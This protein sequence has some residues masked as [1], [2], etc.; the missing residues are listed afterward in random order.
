LF[1]HLI[2]IVFQ[3]NPRLLLRAAGGTNYSS[4]E[5]RNLGLLH[6]AKEE[7]DSH[8]FQILKPHKNVG[9]SVANT[10]FGFHQNNLRT[11]HHQ[12]VIRQPK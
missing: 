4:P 10:I 3:Q 7:L 2:S 5:R 9:S 1:V 6:H 11:A 8:G 12:N